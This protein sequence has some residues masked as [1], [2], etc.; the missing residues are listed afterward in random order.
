MGV[1]PQDLTDPNR[2][3]AKA[4]A[5]DA[6]TKK[7]PSDQRKADAKKDLRNGV[8]PPEEQTLEDAIKLIDEFN[9]LLT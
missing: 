9:V 4:K 6:N 3:D 8:A 2:S 5:K 1:N 7:S